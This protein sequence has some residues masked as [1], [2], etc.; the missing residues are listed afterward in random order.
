MLMSN[1]ANKLNK[2]F[3]R[4]MFNIKLSRRKEPSKKIKLPIGL[5][6]SSL[7]KT[8]DKLIPDINLTRRRKKPPKR[9]K[10]PIKTISEADIKKRLESRKKE[11][12]SVNVSNIVALFAS[13]IYCVMIFFDIFLISLPFMYFAAVL[14]VSAVGFLMLAM[15]EKTNLLNNVFIAMSFI[16]VILSSLIK[17]V[18]ANSGTIIMYFLYCVGYIAVMLFTLR[19]AVKNREKYQSGKMYI[20]VKTLCII[21]SVLFMMSFSVLFVV[22]SYDKYGGFLPIPDNVFFFFNNNV[23]PLFSYSTPELLSHTTV[24][25]SILLKFSDIQVS[26]KQE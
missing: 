6:S 2:F 8:L 19:V 21:T 3:D 25:L 20:L 24:V 22:F 5:N 9:I 13:V 11:S 15:S 1:I 18:R 7:N 10:H 16:V 14:S 23:A 17:E 26:M 12:R 4:I